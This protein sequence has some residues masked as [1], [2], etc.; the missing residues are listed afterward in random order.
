M[1]AFG[2]DY[3]PLEESDYLVVPGAE[4]HEGGEAYALFNNRASLEDIE[5]GLPEILET[6]RERSARTPGNLELSL[7]NVRTLKRSRNVDFDLLTL[8]DEATIYPTFPEAYRDQIATAEPVEI[9]DSTYVLKAT[10]PDAG[11]EYTANELGEIVMN[12]VY[13]INGEGEPFDVAVTQ[14]AGEQYLFKN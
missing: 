11:N 13:T 1:V 8:I 5:A 7:S 14:K 12:G 2:E 10:C 6:H 4:N 9:E 3:E